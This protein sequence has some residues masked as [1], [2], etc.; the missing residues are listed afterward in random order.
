[1]NTEVAEWCLPGVGFAV[2]FVEAAA[3]LHR[4]EESTAVPVGDPGPRRS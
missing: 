4:L 1:M 3:V 2:G